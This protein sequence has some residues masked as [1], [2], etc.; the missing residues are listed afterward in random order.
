MTSTTHSLIAAACLAIAAFQ[1][2]SALAQRVFVAAQGSDANPCTFAL[3]C[4]TF[5]HAHDT[6]AAGG[7]IDVLDPA[8]YGAVT[9]TKAISIQGHGFSGISVV[10]AGT[11]ITIN[12]PS[13][14][15]VALNGLLIEGNGV[16]LTGILFGSGKSLVVENCIVRNSAGDGLVFNSTTSGL[17]TLAV[18]SSYFTDNAGNGMTIATS[19]SGAVTAAV[20]RV[21]LFN[22]GVS[23]LEAFGAGGTGPLTVAATDSVAGNNIGG[24]ASPG[25]LAESN[26]GQSDTTLVLTR[27]TAVGNKTGISAFGSTATVRLTQSTVSGNTIGFSAS[28]S[29]TIFSYGDNT[30]DSNG[31]NT[32]SLTSATK[33]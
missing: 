28:S 6:V 8:G 27:I 17:Q 14:A 18:T 4:R 19:S 2:T 26:P 25:F 9:I 15:A 12:A 24:V 13:N 10:S 31:S 16:S 30:I 21:G 29:G 23:G 1:P 3:P 20:E 7:E 22:N 11:G 5:Q 33:Q 32:G